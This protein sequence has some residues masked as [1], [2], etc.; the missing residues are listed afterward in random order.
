LLP[1]TDA[2]GSR[3][4]ADRLREAV[5]IF[6]FPFQEHNLRVTLSMGIATFPI[7]ALD[8]EELLRKADQ[9]L[10]AAKQEGKNKVILSRDILL[11]KAHP[12]L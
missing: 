3:C 8:I 12:K 1:E 5:E 11:E 7:H 9:S 6:E 10:Y 4:F 2:R